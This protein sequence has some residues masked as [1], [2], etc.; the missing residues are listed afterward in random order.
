MWSVLH[1]VGFYMDADLAN[2]DQLVAPLRNVL[3]CIFCRNSFRTFYETKGA[4]KKGFVSKWLYDIHSMVNDKLHKQAIDEFM[5]S[6]DGPTASKQQFKDAMV[7]NIKVLYREPT[8]EVIQKRFLTDQVVNREHL[9]TVLVV[10]TMKNSTDELRTWLK[11]IEKY[12]PDDSVSRVVRARDMFSE[13]L[14]VKYG[15]DNTRT[16]SIAGLFVAGAC[17]NNVCA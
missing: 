4:P 6:Y 8:F 1:C 9:H 3:P 15:E 13:A 17:I 2:P 14:R 5:E 10:L 7:D 16:R 12:A 11:V